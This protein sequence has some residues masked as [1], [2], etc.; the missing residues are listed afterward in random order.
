M[1]NVAAL[2]G[3]LESDQQDTISKCGHLDCHDI[4]TCEM[5]AKVESNGIIFTNAT[6]RYVTELVMFVGVLN[7]CASIVALE[8]GR[9]AST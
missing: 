7:A 3:C 8:E 1:Q 5:Q 9:C 4:G 6:G 2:T